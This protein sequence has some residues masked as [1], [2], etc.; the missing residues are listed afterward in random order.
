MKSTLWKVFASIIALAS[1][2]IACAT[3]DISSLLNPLPKDD[4]SDSSSGWGTGTDTQSS[5]EYD[6]GG[7]KMTVSQPYYLTWSTPGMDS[8]ENVHIEVSVANTSIDQEAIFGI[9][10]NEQGTTN[11]FYYV[12]VSPD[13]YYA[14][15]KSHIVGKDDKLKEGKSDVI[16]SSSQSMRLGLDCKNGSMTLYVN[17]QQIDS[18]SDSDYTSGSMGLFAGSD[19]QQNGA[20]VVFDDFV[21]TKLEK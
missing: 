12:G 13:G 19:D 18:V 8:L 5:V 9:I 16:S 10:C 7:L 11:N 6:N 1:A 2:S 21:I 3:P 17:G 15:Y 14:F 20:S 4:F